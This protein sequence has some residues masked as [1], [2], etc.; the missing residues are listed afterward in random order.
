M[1]QYDE[2]EL[3]SKLELLSPLSQVAFATAVAARLCSAYRFI[4]SDH[5]YT[6]DV[7]LRLWGVVHTRNSVNEKDWQDT[8]NQI[9]EAIPQEASANRIGEIFQEDALSSVAYAVRCLLEKTD[10][11]KQE[12]AWGAKRAIDLLDQL[13]I[14]SLDLNLQDSNTE[15]LI[16]EHPLIQREL[17]RQER[18]LALL[19]DQ[20]IDAVNQY[21]KSENMLSTQEF[22]ELMQKISK[23]ATMKRR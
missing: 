1:R 7:L 10:Q 21:S 12:A 4:S 20:K 15:D 9:M 23:P 18:D 14:L 3:I 6:N 16:K 8:L 13:V 19:L 2:K 17:L 5:S 22:E 11:S